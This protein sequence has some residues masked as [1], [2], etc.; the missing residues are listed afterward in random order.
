MYQP[1]DPTTFDPP[2]PRGSLF[3]HND[4]G[5]IVSDG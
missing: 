1:C 5:E 3:G 2:P 4:N